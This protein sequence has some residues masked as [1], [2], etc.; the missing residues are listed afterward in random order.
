MQEAILA[1][2]E[3]A[4]IAAASIFCARNVLNI[5]P[6]WPLN[7]ER[8]LNLHD[9]KFTH[10][11]TLLMSVYVMQDSLQSSNELNEELCTP[12]RKKARMTAAEETGGVSPNTD[13]G[14]VSRVSFEE[15]PQDPGKKSH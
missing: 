4:K 12:P 7:L 5:S 14:Y 15:T 9:S 10:Y 8:L 13:E 2:V 3:Q 6:L 1:G 11:S